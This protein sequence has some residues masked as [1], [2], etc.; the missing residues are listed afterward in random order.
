MFWVILIIV[1]WATALLGT[2]FF[3][4]LPF[5]LLLCAL[6]MA[7]DKNSRGE[8]VGFF[9]LA[10]IIFGVLFAILSQ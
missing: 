2:L 9:V 1:F 10:L 7:F 5:I 6:V 3:M 4:A 8:A